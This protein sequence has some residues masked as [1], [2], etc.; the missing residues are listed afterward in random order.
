MMKSALR[1]CGLWL[2]LLVSCGTAWA[3]MTSLKVAKV[4]IKHVGPPAVSDDLVK[5]NIR[6]RP[7]DIY[8]TAAV[9]EDVRNLYA[10]GLFYNI[11]VSDEISDGG[12]VLTYLVQGNPKLTEIKFSGNKKYKD[13]KL[14]KKVTSKVGEPLNER[15]LFTDSQEIQ[16]M[17]Q[18]AGYPSTQVKYVLNID[19]N[20]GRGTV[21][22][23]IQESPKIRI[24]DVQFVGA[25]AF[26][27]RKLR[28]Q[29]KTRRHWMWSWITG[30]GVFMED[31]FEDDKD[32][33][34]QF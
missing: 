14:L 25:Q 8:R 18:K 5:A 13:S 4:Q 16:K 30:S 10:T 3:Q 31:K 7:G 9:D 32:D 15:K 19:E 23:E 21:T 12:V 34:A 11:R 24:I 28:R 26:T 6:V 33:L 27:Q 22:F 20:A 1:F 29:I 2:F 17:Y